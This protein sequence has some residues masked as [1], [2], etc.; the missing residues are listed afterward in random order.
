MTTSE[1][2]SRPTSAPAPITLEVTAKWLSNQTRLNPSLKIVDVCSNQ[3]TRQTAFLPGALRLDW[4]QAFATGPHLKPSPLVFAA[5]MSQLGVGDDDT[6][7]LYDEGEGRRAFSV[8]R[9][10]RG[11]GHR[12][13]FVLVGGRTGWLTQGYSLVREPTR[14]SP[15]SFTVCIEGTFC[16]SSPTGAAETASTHG[17]RRSRRAA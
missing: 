14:F 11:F 9:W 15:S 13:V 5:T 10:L 4:E 1:Y 17:R 6:I 3:S 12:K 8:L 7:V 16:S 2:P